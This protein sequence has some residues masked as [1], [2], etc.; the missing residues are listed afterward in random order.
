MHTECWSKKLKERERFG[1]IHID[2]RI[3]LEWIFEKLNGEIWS[4]FISLRV[5]SIGG[6]L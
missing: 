5:R 2:E 1:D 4:A 6:L 3:I